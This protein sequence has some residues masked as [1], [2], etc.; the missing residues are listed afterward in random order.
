MTCSPGGG[1]P[2]LES[3]AYRCQGLCW[4]LVGIE[5][6]FHRGAAFQLTDLRRDAKH[7]RR[8]ER[9]RG[10]SQLGRVKSHRGVRDESFVAQSGPAEEVAWRQAAP[11]QVAR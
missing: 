4:L 8:D 3:D 9:Q 5:L 1:A 10:P 11:A 6:S 2:R 7:G